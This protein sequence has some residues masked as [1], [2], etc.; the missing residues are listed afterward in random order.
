MRGRFYS[1]RPGGSGHSAHCLPCPGRAGS[2]ESPTAGWR[3][4]AFVWPEVASCPPT[5]LWIRTKP[6][7]DTR[8]S[9][10]YHETIDT[11]RWQ[12]ISGSSLGKT[13]LRWRQRSSRPHAHTAGAER[14]REGN[15]LGWEI[16]GG[17]GATR[18]GRGRRDQSNWPLGGLPVHGG[19]PSRYHCF[20]GGFDAGIGRGDCPLREAAAGVAQCQLG[21]NL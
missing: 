7:P 15:Q 5:T 13:I 20:T 12:R 14:W 16:V 2:A 3:A 9:W 19:K 11:C 18:G 6:I 17:V 1:G 21:H 4:I 10:S 8:R